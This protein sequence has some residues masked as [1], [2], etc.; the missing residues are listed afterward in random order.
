[1]STDEFNNKGEQAMATNYKGKFS[2]NKAPAEQKKKVPFRRR[3]NRFWRIAR[4]DRRYQAVLCLIVCFLT[5]L[6]ARGCQYS[7]D[8]NK[9]E[10]QIAEIS[11]GYEATIQQLNDAHQEEIMM[12]RAEYEEITPEERVDME[13]KAIARVLYG[14]ARNNSERDQRTLT[15]G[16][17]N[18][19][20]SVGFP[21]NVENVCSQASQWMGYSADNPVLQNLYE[22]AKTE[23]EKWYNGD[24]PVLA[25]YVYMTWS[26]KEITLRDTYEKTANTRYWQ[27]N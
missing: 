10:E 22:V 25:D 3:W 26:S 1:M 19:V 14:N 24:R 6:I 15:W 8:K 4:K 9:F 27:S 20:D 7:V 21:N 17:L 16:I 2:K 12:L 5:S 18:R 11:A 23:L 13:A